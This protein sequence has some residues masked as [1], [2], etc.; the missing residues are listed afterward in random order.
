MSATTTTTTTTIIITNKLTV[1]M[2]TPLRQVKRGHASMVVA[3]SVSGQL[4]ILAEHRPLLA[5]L[6]AGVVEV[7]GEQQQVDRYAVSGGFIEVDRN[8]VT[9]LAETAERSDEID[10]ERAQRSVI[11]AEAR[12]KNLTPV[13]ADYAEELRRLQRNRARLQVGAH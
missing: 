2:L 10:T 8:V 13:D 4:G 9:I 7:H 3:P 11:E 5:D 6:D 12:L 1:A